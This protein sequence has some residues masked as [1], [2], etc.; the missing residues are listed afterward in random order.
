M[1]PTTNKPQSN[2]VPKTPADH[3][4]ARNVIAQ[5][6]EAN[7]A[8]HITAH[9][10]LQG[11][12]DAANLN[13]LLLPRPERIALR[14][15]FMASE[16]IVSK[17]TPNLIAYQISEADKNYCRNNASGMTAALRDQFAAAAARLPVVRKSVIEYVMGWAPKLF[18]TPA[19]SEDRQ[20]LYEER[21]AKEATAEALES[22]LAA[23][24]RA[25]ARFEADPTPEHHGQVMG[26]LSVVNA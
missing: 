19:S 10:D 4:A 25:I 20:K 11:R 3:A 8:A 14:L 17:I 1:T 22:N 13:P 23:C 26:T 7:A 6:I 15:E 9:T 5:N 21:E 24:E 2:T 18:A 12:E 16:H